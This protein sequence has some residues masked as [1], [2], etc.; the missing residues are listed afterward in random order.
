MRGYKW[1]GVDID[2]LD[3][4]ARWLESIGKRDAVK[5]GQDVPEKVDLEEMLRK[6]DEAASKVQGIL[7]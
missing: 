4:L 5:R 6:A 7:A 2:G 1:S 3:N